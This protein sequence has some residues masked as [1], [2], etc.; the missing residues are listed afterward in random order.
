[1]QI[2]QI[3]NMDCGYWIPKGEEEHIISYSFKGVSKDSY[4]KYYEFYESSKITSMQRK[5]ILKVFDYVSSVIKIK[6]LEVENSAEADL[7]IGQSLDELDSCF[8]EVKLQKEDNWIISKAAITI[9]KYDLNDSK[10]KYYPNYS[11]RKILRCLGQVLGLSLPKSHIL[12]PDVSVINNSEEVMLD[13]YY[14]TEFLEND[15]IS[16]SS[17]YNLTKNYLRVARKISQNTRNMDKETALNKAIKEN[18]IEGVKQLIKEGANLNIPLKP[19]DKI[20]LYPLS[21]AILSNNSQMV[22]LLINAGAEV[23]VIRGDAHTMLDDACS[24]GSIEIVEI[25]LKAGADPNLY[26]VSN[27]GL[28]RIPLYTAIFKKHTDICKALLDAGANTNISLKLWKNRSIISLSALYGNTDI[29]KLFYKKGVK[30]DLATAFMLG[31]S[32]KISKIIKE[33]NISKT[34]LEGLLEQAIDCNNLFLTNALI[35]FGVSVSIHKLNTA[36]MKHN[37]ELV[38][39]LAPAVKNINQ[40]ILES[41]IL[42]NAIKYNNEEMV[43]ALLENGADPNIRDKNGYNALHIAVL[44]NNDLDVNCLVK[45]GIDINAVDLKDNNALHLAATTEHLFKYAEILMFL[46]IDVNARNMNNKTVLHLAIEHD[47]DG[48]IVGLFKNFGGNLNPQLSKT[49][50]Y[51]Y[52]D[53]A[54]NCFNYKVVPSLL[55]NRAKCGLIAAIKL[56]LKSKVHEMV[57]RGADLKSVDINGNTPLHL[58]ALKGYLDVVAELV[59]RGAKLNILNKENQTVLDIAKEVGATIYNQNKAIITYLISS[60]ALTAEELKHLKKET[61][62]NVKARIIKSNVIDFRTRKIIY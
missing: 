12:L 62:S 40:Y 6:F 37:I 20:F 44:K 34:K 3:K 18:N 49:N 8:Y 26:G 36:V 7:I 60:G 45:H 1:M 4:N 28:V 41:T 52:I 35:D 2:S 27:A 9:D 30:I 14:E 42:H 33:Q 32:E 22:Q 54:L 13:K 58:A 46:G 31:M 29:V 55:I 39:I 47:Y 50:H 61:K 38:K 56:D 59:L 17:R 16:L 48:W 19:E 51:S 11:F 53:F 57:L 10:I 25:L 43:Y 21:E 23:N 5:L 15:L 24:A